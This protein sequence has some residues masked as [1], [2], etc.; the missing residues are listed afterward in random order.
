LWRKLIK[1]NIDSI[2]IPLPENAG[3]QRREIAEFDMDR[4]PS[5]SKQTVV[6]G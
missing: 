6:S 2:G 4:Q 1:E 3:K 5:L